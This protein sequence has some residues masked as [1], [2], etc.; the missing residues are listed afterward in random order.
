VQFLGARPRS[1]AEIR[2]HLHGKRYDDAAIDGAIDKLRAQRYID[3]LDFAKYWVEQRA[4]FR[5]KGD[6]ALIDELVNK[7]VA[8]ET[9]KAAMGEVPAE[10]EADRARRALARMITRWQTLETGERRRKIHAF[11]AGRGFDYDVIE[12]VIERPEP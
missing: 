9:I 6:R 4:R 10:S 3:D 2:R 1:V 5:P 12:E 11:L 8:R 7:G